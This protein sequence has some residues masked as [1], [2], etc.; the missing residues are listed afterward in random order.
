VLRARSEPNELKP[1]PGLAALPDLFDESRRAGQ[2]IDVDQTGE[3]VQLPTGLDLAAYRIVQ[4]ALTNARKHAPGAPTTVNLTWQPDQ[5]QIE[6]V[7]ASGGAH[8][9]GNGTGHG[10][11]GMRE[12]AT[13][14]GGHVDAGRTSDGFHVRAVLPI[15]QA[16]A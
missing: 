6:V 3:A 14:Y 1:Q 11:I 12:R 13:L 8:L 16:A 15:E 10:L 5:L 7:N 9:N 4:E 2:E